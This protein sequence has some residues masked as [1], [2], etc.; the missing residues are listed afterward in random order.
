MKVVAILM[1]AF[2]LPSCISTVAIPIGGPIPAFK[3]IY[4]AGKGIVERMLSDKQAD[5]IENAAADVP[6]ETEVE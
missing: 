1:L 2:M 4:D 3:S 5:E 6:A